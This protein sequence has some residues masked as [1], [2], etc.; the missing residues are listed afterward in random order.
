MVP[1]AWLGRLL[2]WRDLLPQW[3]L[4]GDPEQAIKTLATLLP[5]PADREAALAIARGIFSK[6]DPLEP[7]VQERMEAIQK[8]LDISP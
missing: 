3:F 1:G 4:A 7:E 2:R 5:E 8:V 6:D